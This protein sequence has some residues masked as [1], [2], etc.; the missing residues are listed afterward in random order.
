MT[1]KIKSVQPMKNFTLLVCFQ[2]GIEKQ[3]DMSKVISMFPQF[4]VLEKDHELYE[5][6][7][8]DVGGYGIAWN[9]DLD[10]DAEEI[11]EEGIET[12]KIEDASIADLLAVSLA[13]ARIEAGLTQKQLAETSGIYQADIS[14]IERGLAN[15]SLST[16]K[17]LA[18]GMGMA[19]KIEF[20]KI[21]KK[22]FRDY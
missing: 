16:L 18:D 4:S 11:W 14:K 7:Y 5:K 9:D 21:E 17:R 2:N 12:G 20:K 13:S 10:M 3:Y 22:E 19:L 6:V 1:H 8:V 15:P